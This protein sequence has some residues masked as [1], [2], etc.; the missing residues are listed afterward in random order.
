MEEQPQEPE[1]KTTDLIVSHNCADALRA[2]LKSIELSDDRELTEILV[3]DCGSLDGS[4]LIDSEFPAVTVLRLPR[5]FG[6]TKARNIGARTAKGEFLLFLEPE[7]DIAADT[8][9]RLVAALEAEPKAVAV[10][11]LLADVDGKPVTHAGALPTPGELCEIWSGEEPWNA[12]VPSSPVPPN[13]LDAETVE[14]ECP[15]PRA[16][17]VYTKAVKGMNYFD[18]RYGHFGSNLEL[19]AQALRANRRIL[20]LPGSRAV[21]RGDE[22]LWQP[23]GAAAEADLAGDFGTGIIAYTGKHFGWS[24][25]L[26][27]RLKMLA[28]SVL[29]FDL[30]AV[31][32]LIGGAK[33]DGSQQGL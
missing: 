31:S 16:V 23:E 6:M 3:V 15:D 28:K 17:L 10:C 9:P 8:I 27:V 18:E 12:P 26:K 30:G 11:P 21:V 5:H 20:L 19:A 1:V 7:I 22:G 25:A 33:I 2:C 32:R 29:K 14:V 24:A 13:E 4:E